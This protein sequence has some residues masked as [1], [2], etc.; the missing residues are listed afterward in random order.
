[1]IGSI[2]LKVIQCDKEEFK[3]DWFMIIMMITFV[4]IHLHARYP[5]FFSS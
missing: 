2:F 3:V 1:M 4:V 5:C